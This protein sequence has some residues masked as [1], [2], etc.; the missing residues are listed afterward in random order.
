M[1]GELLGLRGKVP[2]VSGELAVTALSAAEQLEEEFPGAFTVNELRGSYK[3]NVCMGESLGLYHPA[4]LHNAKLHI[5]SEGHVAAIAARKG[6]QSLFQVGV[7]SSNAVATLAQSLEKLPDPAKR[8]LGFWLPHHR[9]GTDQI[10]VSGLLDAPTRGSTW[11]PSKFEPIN[12][13]GGDAVIGSTVMHGGNL[14]IVRGVNTFNGTLHVIPSSLSG[15]LANSKGFERK[16]S[17]CTDVKTKRTG[18]FRSDNCQRHCVHGATNN[19]RRNL[20]C[21]ECEQIPNEEDFRKRAQARASA[22]AAG[23]AS[24]FTNAGYL[25]HG[26]LLGRHRATVKKYEAERL[27]RLRTLAKLSSSRKRAQK[28]EAR[29]KELKEAGN[30]SSLV[31]DL[32]EC[33]DRGSFEDKAAALDF[34]KDLVRHA[35]N[36]DED[37]NPSQG[38]K[39]SEST[40]RIY[41]L[42]RTLGGPKSHHVLKGNIGGPHVSTTERHWRKHI[43]NVEPGLHAE[44]F[45]AI[46]EILTG[47]VEKLGLGEGERLLAEVAVDETGIIAKGTYR[48]A[49]DA[50]VGF[51]GRVDDE[52]HKCRPISIALGDDDETQG[53]IQ[54]S[55]LWLLV[56]LQ[57]TLTQAACACHRF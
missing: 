51:C 31:R 32:H 9:Y 18:T 10:D 54:G 30:L 15:T 5:G 41:C 38:T 3:C 57:S 43:T 52:N 45:E 17:E 44:A 49:T 35:K 27:V 25:T 7:V 40:H 24:K 56:P 20:M 21:L 12:V 48:Q 8:C 33:H 42:L 1:G 4:L 29:L 11:Y 19:L 50:I 22:A 47:Y 2:M 37:G 6:Q 46:A 36:C 28:A 55:E 13:S 53:K 34:I 23:G 39:Y 26:E 14:Q 16:A